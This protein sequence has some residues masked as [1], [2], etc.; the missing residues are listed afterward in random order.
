MTMELQERNLATA[1]LA[2]HKLSYARNMVR[3]L[4]A[5]ISLLAFFNVAHCYDNGAPNSRLPPMGWSSWVALAPGAH[6]PVYDFCDE[7]SVKHAI[8]AFH[9]VGLYDAGYRHFHLDDCWAGGR[10]D[11]G[12]LVPEPRHFPNGIKAVVDYAHSK[13]L[14]FGIYTSAGYQV[15]VGDRPGSKDH[16]KEDAKAFADWG[17]DWL[18]M[19]WCFTEGMEPEETY[20]EMSKALNRTGRPIHFNMCEWGINDPWKWGPDLAQSWRMGPDH[21]PTWESTK[22]TIANSARIPPEDTGRPYSWNDMDFI[23]T[24]NGHQASKVRIDSEIVSPHMSDDEFRTEFSMWAISASPLMVTTPIMNCTSA[25]GPGSFQ[26]AGQT[27]VGLQHSKPLLR[28]GTYPCSISK[29]EQLSDAECEEGWSFGCY[30]HNISMWADHGCS[31]YFV[32]DHGDHSVICSGENGFTVCTPEVLPDQGSPALLAASDDKVRK[33]HK[34]LV[35][36][37]QGPRKLDV[38]PLEVEP[39]V[40]PRQGKANC[41]GWMTSLQKEILLNK[42]VIAVNQDVTP[43][44]RPVKESSSVWARHMSDGSIAVALYNNRNYPR[45]I[46]VDF[47]DLGWPE[48]QLATVRDLWKHQDMGVAKGQYPPADAALGVAEVCKHCTV[49]LRLR[50]CEGQCRESQPPA[51]EQA[52]LVA[53]SEGPFHKKFK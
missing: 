30:H 19:D 13:G 36:K 8:D 53:T 41:V 39:W 10:D 18:K 20:P 50:R 52:S 12:K 16:F 24:G 45:N 17:V 26:S 15:C 6:H 48:E 51:G 11:E 27:L 21:V 23:H 38:E 34:H 42:E 25:E 31:A 35:R 4:C 32:L 5:A 1:G 49:L 46:Y 2:L 3:G 22:K 33:P 29:A 43:Q 14:T 44:G 37:E 47:A 28:R 9:E 7:A 40:E